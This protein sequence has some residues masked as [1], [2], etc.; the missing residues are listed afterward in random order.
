L[1]VLSSDES[2]VDSWSSKGEQLM[3]PFARMED[4]SLKDD[5]NYFM[6]LDLFVAESSPRVT[7]TTAETSSW[8]APTVLQGRRKIRVLKQSVG[9]L[10]ESLQGIRVPKGTAVWE[11]RGLIHRKECGRRRQLA[12]SSLCRRL[13]SVSKREICRLYLMAMSLD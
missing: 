10:G 8:V 2:D 11:W 6:A 12:G 9:M 1:I 7:L 3:S 4:E 5:L 13:G